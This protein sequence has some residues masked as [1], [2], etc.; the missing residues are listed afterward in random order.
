[1]HCV[2]SRFGYP[3]YR[4]SQLVRIIDVLL[5]IY[6]LIY[7]TDEF[8]KRNYYNL[9]LIVRY[10]THIFVWLL[11]AY[12]VVRGIVKNYVQARRTVNNTI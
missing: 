11:K 10:N 1:M 4:W 6:I 2:A 9:A 3:N 5:Y 7:K 12:Y 8:H